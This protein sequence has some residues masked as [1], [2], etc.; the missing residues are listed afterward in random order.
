MLTQPGF[1]SYLG[2][3]LES[4]LDH[5]GAACIFYPV[6]SHRVLHVTP[7]HTIFSFPFWRHSCCESTYAV[8][9]ETNHC[10][11]LENKAG[12]SMPSLSVLSPSP[13]FPHIL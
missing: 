9:G 13:V 4:E 5:I 1:A 7:D 10:S 6:N 12:N 2:F 8:C 11:R 3:L